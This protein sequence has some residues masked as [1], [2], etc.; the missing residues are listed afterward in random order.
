MVEPVARGLAEST[1]IELPPHRD[2]SGSAAIIGTHFR[3]VG[4]FASPYALNCRNIVMISC[5][6]IDHPAYVPRQPPTTAITSS[7]RC[8]V[9]SIS[10]KFSL[11]LISCV[12][13]SPIC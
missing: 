4:Q 11:R 3:R 12:I 6:K 8:L 7:S 13:A 10:Q 5:S 2:P 1:S 9:M